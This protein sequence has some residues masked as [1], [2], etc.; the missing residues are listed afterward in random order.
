MRRLHVLRLRQR[1]EVCSWT[2]YS[3]TF[4]L[5]SAA[6]WHKQVQTRLR[7]LPAWAGSDAEFIRFQAVAAQLAWVYEQ[8]CQVLHGRRAFT[9]L[10]QPVVSGWAAVVDEGE[11]II[12]DMLGSAD[13]HPLSQ[14]SAGPR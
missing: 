4:G 1:I 6:L 9:D 2:L 5:E 7:L 14:P 12:D 10:P 3:R 8:C 11:G 13:Q